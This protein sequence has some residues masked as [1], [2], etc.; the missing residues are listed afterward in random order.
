VVGKLVACGV[1]AGVG[2]SAFAAG[3]LRG[4]VEGAQGAAQ[5]INVL[6]RIA[7]CVGEDGCEWVLNQPDSRGQ[8]SVSLISGLRYHTPYVGTPILGPLTTVEVAGPLR[9]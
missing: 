5:H 8:R 2:I 4:Y 9:S 1:V 3:W 6:R 7:Q